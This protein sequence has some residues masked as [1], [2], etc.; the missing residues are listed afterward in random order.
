MAVISIL[1]ATGF[2]GRNLTYV[3]AKNHS[4][5]V[6]SRSL[7]EAQK[8][9]FVAPQ[10]RIKAF[11]YK[12]KLDHIFYNTDIVINL[13]GTL[14][15]K[16]PAQYFDVHYILPKKIAETA[17]Q[18]G[19]KKV[20]HVSAMGA[21]ENSPS[22]YAQS[23]ALGEKV[24]MDNLNNISIF[25]PSLIVGKG[26]Q[27][28]N[29]FAQMAQVSPFLPLVGPEPNGASFAPIYV[30]DVVKAIEASLTRSEKQ[31]YE[32]TGHSIYSWRA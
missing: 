11:S 23:K 8:L 32:I 29:K 15:P 7:T 5:R 26:D 10:G 17:T 4:I 12:D 16:K 31:I 13:C 2:L 21:D 3:L 30:G 27:F 20:I 22:R 28:F 24:L 1:G 6:A 19:V 25:R 14:M 18:Y 9:S